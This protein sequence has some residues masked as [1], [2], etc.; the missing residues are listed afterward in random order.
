MPAS[1]SLPQGAQLSRRGAEAPD[2]LGARAL[3]D[4]RISAVIPTFNRVK[5]IARAIDS[6][7]LQTPGVL[8]VIIVDDGST[9][10]TLDLLTAWGAK[11]PRL[12][13]IEWG[14]N[15]GASLARNAAWL[16]LWA[17]GSRFWIPLITGCPAS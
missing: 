17:I 12:R 1:P 6:V 7:L 16:R 10:G 13:V 15:G 5:T 14:R 8:E 3:D 4:I 9:D 2:V 11:E